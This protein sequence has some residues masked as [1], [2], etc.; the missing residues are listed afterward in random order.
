[1]ILVASMC[2]ARADTVH[3]QEK[4][5]V[6]QHRGVWVENI[7]VCPTEMT[8]RIIDH[9]KE[10]GRQVRLININQYNPNPNKDCKQDSLFLVHLKKRGTEFPYEGYTRY[11]ERNG[12]FIEHSWG[13]VEALPFHLDD[14]LQRVFE[15][16]KGSTF[17]TQLNSHGVL[18]QDGTRIGKNDMKAIIEEIHMAYR[19]GIERHI[20]GPVRLK[21]DTGGLVTASFMT[22]K[23]RPVWYKLSKEAGWW[24][25]LDS[26]ESRGRVQMPLPGS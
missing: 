9:F 25:I 11:I 22:G 18:L 5:R 15:V 17:M 21:E 24:S 20:D 13:E 23:G 7:G 6:F 4:R 8:D 1:M 3:A 12:S 19:P 10:K 14:P 16:I 2:L 26:S